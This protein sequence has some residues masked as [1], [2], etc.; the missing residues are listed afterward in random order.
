M[1]STL[2]AGSMPNPFFRKPGRPSSAITRLA[3]AKP[4]ATANSSAE[5]LPAV[6]DINP[7]TSAAKPGW[8]DSGIFK[9][10][11]LPFYKR[12]KDVEQKLHTLL[13]TVRIMLC[14]AVQKQL[15]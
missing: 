6:L 14:C 13:P 2:S 5:N 1:S 3:A 4:D 7:S 9:E 8:F 12:N 15:L 10:K 11:R